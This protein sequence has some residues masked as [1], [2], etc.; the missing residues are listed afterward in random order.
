[1]P[2]CSKNNALNLSI[3]SGPISWGILCRII[4][5]NLF[6]TLFLSTSSL[7]SSFFSFSLSSFTLSSICLSDS[8][9]VFS[10][11]FIF[12]LNL[13]VN[14]LACCSFSLTI[15][16]NLL[17]SFW[18]FSLSSSLFCTCSW[19]TKYSC[20]ACF[21]FS[22]SCFKFLIFSFLSLIFCSFS[23]I[24]W[25]FSLIDW[26][27]FF[28]SCN[29]LLIYSWFD[30]IKGKICSSIICPTLLIAYSDPLSISWLIMSFILGISNF[31]PISSKIK[32][33][34]SSFCFPEAAIEAQLAMAF[35]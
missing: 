21:A 20:A 33:A 1:M 14:S 27:L 6:S 8:N 30:W 24:D 35:S 26:S 32:Y 23:L 11:S 18:R 10:N 9:F 19:F 2:I 4:S 17:T 16:F 34:L 7:I 13:S 12:W 5:C 3:P 31:F 25:S 22:I 28:P 15:S 29:I